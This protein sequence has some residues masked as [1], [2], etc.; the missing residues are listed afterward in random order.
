[1]VHSRYKVGEDGK[2]AYERQKGRKCKLEMVPLGEFVRYKKLGETSQE[3]KSLESTWFEGV[4]LGHARGSSE[5]LACTQDGAVKAW[6]IRR[7]PE[8]ERWGAE[9]ITEMKGTPTRP[10]ILPGIHIPISIN[11]GQDNADGH[12]IEVTARQEEKR[13]R[14]VYLKAED[15]ELHGY[16]EGCEGCSRLKT[17]GMEARP[18][19]E[20]CRA[21]IEEELEK[22]GGPRWVKAK[23]REMA[24]DAADA[25]LARARAETEKRRRTDAEE[26]LGRDDAEGRS[27]DNAKSERV[28]PSSSNDHVK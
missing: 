9:A 13:A 16:T 22:D 20:T 18:H 6:A 8:G 4:W 24:R 27:S 1:M 17:G 26:E 7:E 21:R 10:G 15:F 11:I 5:A 28:E 14:R 3:R 19:T 2:T 12:L 25:G 23:A